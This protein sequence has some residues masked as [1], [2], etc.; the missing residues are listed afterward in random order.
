[1]AN[2]S[3]LL[4]L[5]DR[6]LLTQIVHRTGPEQISTNFDV[7]MNW[8]AT[9]FADFSA[10]TISSEQSAVAAPI[11]FDATTSRIESIVADQKRY[12]DLFDAIEELSSLDEEDSHFI[13]GGTA[14]A[15]RR[16]LSLLSLYSVTAPQIFPHGGDAVVF[17]WSA[18][19][20][21]T[22]YVTVGDGF[23]SLRPYRL[24]EPLSPSVSFNEQ[25]LT[26]LILQLGGKQWQAVKA[27]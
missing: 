21:T 11:H 3:S 17:K 23:V 1:L 14:R 13:D 10:V 25:E 20:E 6:N 8:S 2:R 27:V 5:V 7:A 19:D 18:A 4:S 12:A 26:A 9:G 15:A 24:G 16:F 22:A